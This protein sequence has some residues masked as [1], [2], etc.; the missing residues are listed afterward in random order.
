MAD[1]LELTDR[2][3][4]ELPQMLEEHRGIVTAL[5]KLRAS[6]ERAGRADIVEFAQALTEHARIEEEVM[7]PAALLV[8][9]VVRQRL[10]SRVPGSA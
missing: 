8:G 4:A 10:G 6:A 3:E 9:Q 1:V 5:D 2:L 7:Y